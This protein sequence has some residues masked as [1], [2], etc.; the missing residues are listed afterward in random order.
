M[1][2]VYKVFSISGQFAPARAHTLPSGLLA[3]L[4]LGIT[5]VHAQSADYKKYGRPA[6]IGSP[7]AA[8]PTKSA[9][10]TKGTVTT[11]SLTNGQG[12][13]IRLFASSNP[14]SEPHASIDKTNPSNILVSANTAA[15]SQGYY[16]STD[17]GRTWSGSDDLPYSAQSLGDPSTAYDASGNAYIAAITIA[18]NGYFIQS[19]ST[20]GA[21]WTYPVRGSL[22]PNIFDKEMIAADNGANSP[23]KNNLYGAWT[24]YGSPTTV[25]FNRSIDNGRT[26]STP[27]ILKAGTN[28]QGTNV[29][30][31]PQGDVYVCWADYGNGGSQANGIGFARSTDGGASFSPYTIAFPYDGIRQDG[32]NT[33]FNNVGVTDFPSMAVD[34]GPTHPGRIYIT[35][36]TKENGNGKA[37]IQVRYSDNQGASWSAPVR[38]STPYGRQNWVPWI[39]VDECTGDVS[40]VYYSFDTASGYDTNTYVS[41]SQ[42]GGNSFTHL[43]VS[44]AS[45]VTAPIASP[46][47]RADYGGDYLA[48]TAYAGKVYPVWSDNRSGTW[49]LYTS[50]LSYVV[51]AGPAQLCAGTATYTVPNLPTGASVA[52][53]SSNTSVAT[54]SASGEVTPVASGSVTFTATIA[55]GCAS[56]LIITKDVQITIPS[57]TGSYYCGGCSPSGYFPIDPNGNSVKTGTITVNISQTSGTTYSFSAYP[58]PITVTS[59]TSFYFYIDSSSSAQ[60]RQDVTITQTNNTICS[61]ASQTFT[62]FA[63]MSYYYVATP[64]PTT[65]ELTVT[66]VD[67]SQADNT[68][69]STTAEPFD[70]ELYDGFGKKVKSEHSEGGKA[71]LYVLDLPNGLY[72]LRAGKGKEAISEQIQ[73]SH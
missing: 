16:Y 47:T 23:F 29:Q 55:T 3:I 10:P 73:V 2:D 50:P 24:D 65:S 6:F 57:I 33:T 36:P 5:T 7:A 48:I 59:P 35:Y 64:N 52:W 22:T 71:K 18:D 12:D 40:V 25:Q 62:W 32:Q 13:D 44:D 43:K 56:T 54:I 15:Y 26:F 30:T 66:A 27:I 9:P 42:D 8:K 58:G 20:K 72:H 1:R 49:Q 28:G 51:I 34:K 60:W 38:A 41:Y 69:V 67:K 46:N 21:T 53:S 14:Q 70:A 31:G 19:S 63:S 61:P 17:G 68:V 4:M 39:A 45:H 37:I 11:N